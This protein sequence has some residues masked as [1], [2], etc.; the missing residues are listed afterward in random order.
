[1]TLCA[2]S[3]RLFAPRERT[4]EPHGAHLGNLPAPCCS[5]ITHMRDSAA[6]RAEVDH[7]VLSENSAGTLADATMLRL[8]SITFPRTEMRPTTEFSAE[9]T[10]LALL[11]NATAINSRESSRYS[12]NARRPERPSFASLTQAILAPGRGT[13]PVLAPC[14]S[15]SAMGHCKR[16][17]I[18]D[19][20]TPSLACP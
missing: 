18:C 20:M 8:S 5:S 19:R 17:R 2:T 7:S 4:A 16:S 11:A 15:C 9:P 1:M 12:L 3:S 6:Q 13:F 10:D 14:N